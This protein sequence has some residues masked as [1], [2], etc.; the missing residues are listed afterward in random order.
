MQLEQGTVLG[1]CDD[2]VST[3]HAI[4][5]AA[6]PVGMLRFEPPA[7]ATPWVGER[8]C[9]VAGAVA[10]QAPSRLRVV[11]GDFTAPQSEDCLTLTIW[12]PSG[13][14]RSKPVLAWLHGGA[15]LTGGGGI[16]IYSGETLAREG[17]VVVVGINYRLGALGF[18]HYPGVTNGNMGLLDQKAALEW[19]QKNIANFGGDPA[20]V[21]LCGQSAGAASIAHLLTMKAEPRFRRC[22]LQ[23]A[24]L[25][26]EALPP[27]D[28]TTNAEVFFRELGVEPGA[29]DFRQQL[30]AATAS[31]IVAAQN[32]TMIKRAQDL[33]LKPGEQYLPFRPVSDGAILPLDNA[34]AFDAAAARRDV[35]IGTTREE[36]GSF[37]A[38]DPQIQS[39]T[40]VP[41]PES[42]VRR[43]KGRR[44]GGTA[45]DLLGDYISEK[46]FFAPSLRWAEQAAAAGRRAFVYS[47]DWQSP[48]RR[49]G[50]CHCLELPFVFGTW[51]A[52]SRAPML[53]D[54]DIGRAQK[55][56]A[57]M[58]AAWLGFVTHGDPSVAEI[59]R[60]PAFGSASPEIMLIGELFEAVNAPRFN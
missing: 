59:P 32:A 12:T 33:R 60:W 51:N 10:P 30:N 21:T 39:L 16:D 44:P 7:P 49:L 22:I 52:F 34:A 3:F 24:P 9:T 46:A 38:F 42:L 58:R 8:D 53:A 27:Q 4:P 17:D 11:M 5:Y 48:G 18:L 45:A 23:S 14:K 29:A 15:F 28:A 47:F 40:S 50:A 2:L 37:F 41:L 13:G 36:Y 57:S 1:R 55:I 54:A 35:L 26:L 19:I 31:E 25:G 43:L 6:P 56:G 20:L